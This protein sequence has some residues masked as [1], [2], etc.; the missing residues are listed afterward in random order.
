MLTNKDSGLNCLFRTNTFLHSSLMQPIGGVEKSIYPT[1]TYHLQSKIYSFISRYFL[2]AL[3]ALFISQYVTLKSALNQLI[4]GAGDQISLKFVF[5]WFRC[6]LFN[7]HK[8]VSHF[9][10]E[11]S[12]HFD[13]RFIVAFFLLLFAII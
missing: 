1:L 4:G 10:N 12:S 11:F 2:S 5:W 6:F 13:D 8:F 7:L 9:S 3:H